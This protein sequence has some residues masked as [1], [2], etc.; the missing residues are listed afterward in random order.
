MQKRIIK[1]A[2]TISEIGYIYIR[3]SKVIKGNRPTTHKVLGTK[4]F[5]VYNLQASYI[6]VLNLSIYDETNLYTAL[7]YMIY[8]GFATV[9]FATH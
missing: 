8:Y 6:S 2:A 3:G 5:V 4:Y 1:A 7:Y 9:D